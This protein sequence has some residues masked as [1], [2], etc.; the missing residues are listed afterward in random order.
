[1]LPE[2]LTG[3]QPYPGTSLEKQIAG[4]MNK[5]PPRPSTMQ[6]GVPSQLDDVIAKGMAK[7]PNERFQSAMALAD[8]AHDALDD[9]AIVASAPTVFEP[10]VVRPAPPAAVRVR[11]PGPE[12]TGSAPLR[13]AGFRGAQTVGLVCLRCRVIGCTRVDLVVFQW[14]DHTLTQI[15][16][17]VWCGLIFVYG[18]TL[19]RS[20]QLDMPGASRLGGPTIHS[21]PTMH[22]D[23]P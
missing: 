13:L 14:S 2:C 10:T 12:T 16:F 9:R 3:S 8:A 17:L 23:H 11:A 6:A 21:A 7:D 20:G 19:Y 22:R 18:L 4:H 15:M 1:M 5:P